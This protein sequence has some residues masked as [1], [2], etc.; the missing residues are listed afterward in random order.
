MTM[1]D[2]ADERFVAALE[3]LVRRED[4]GALATLRRGLGKPPGTV[5]ELFPYVVPYLPTDGD[6]RRAW[7]FF[8]VAPLFAFHPVSW[9][10]GESRGWTNF[11]AS[12]A[13]LA[14][15]LDHGSAGLEARF[16]RLLAAEREELPL[17]LYRMLTL[18][19]PHQV[20][21]SWVRLLRDLVQWDHPERFIQRQ[22]A[23]AFVELRERREESSEREESV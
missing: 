18:F 15:R 19:R 11:G 23:R 5:I 22:W 10:A 7:V 17:Q 3:D 21:V 6:E 2:R 16:L 14:Q 4:R 20:P 13:R 8:A 9:P 1:Q 12:V